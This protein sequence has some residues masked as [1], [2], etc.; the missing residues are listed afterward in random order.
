MLAWL[1]LFNWAEAEKV[2]KQWI[3]MNRERVL[4][5]MVTFV[6]RRLIFWLSI[7][8]KNTTRYSVFPKSQWLYKRF[9]W[10]CLVIYCTNYLPFSFLHDLDT[11]NSHNIYILL[12]I[13]HIRISGFIFTIRFTI[14]KNMGVLYMLYYLWLFLT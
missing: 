6:L 1:L 9:T 3:S 5:L 4:F 7:S 11:F 8:N 12:N 14:K 13:W 2:N 10:F